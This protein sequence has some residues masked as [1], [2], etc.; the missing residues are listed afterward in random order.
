LPDDEQITTARDMAILGSALINHF[1][2]YYRYFDEDSFT[3]AGVV[4]RNHNHLKRRYDGMD[5]IKTGYIRASGFNLVASAKRNG[6]RLIAVVFGGRSAIARDN[7]MAR[8]LD[9]SFA[10]VVAENRAGGRFAVARG[11]GD[12]NDG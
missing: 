1:P 5:G 2:Q 3:Y 4:H 9:Q 12:G 8:L 7:Q 6:V 11:E 10:D